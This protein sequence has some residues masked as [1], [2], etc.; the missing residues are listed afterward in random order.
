MNNAP[1]INGNIRESKEAL[2]RASEG[3]QK[4]WFAGD[5]RLPLDRIDSYRED[6][7]WIEKE[8]PMIRKVLSEFNNIALNK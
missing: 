1:E 4:L 2:Q 7:Y 6:L 3:L 5:T 8:L